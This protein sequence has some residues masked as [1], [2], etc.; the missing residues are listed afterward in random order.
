MSAPVRAEVL[1]FRGKSYRALGDEDRAR[2]CLRKALHLAEEHQVNRVLF[3]AE[4][5]LEKEPVSEERGTST[6][7][8]LPEPQRETVNA[9]RGPLT[10]M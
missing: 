1:L 10:R 4:K 3:E 7:L 2:T 6:P 8:N 5:L 9:V